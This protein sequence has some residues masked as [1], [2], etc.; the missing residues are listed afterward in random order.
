MDIDGKDRIFIKN[1]LVNHE[2]AGGFL[3]YNHPKEGLLVAVLKKE[4]ELYLIP[5][6][7]IKLDETP[8]EAALRELFEELNLHIIPKIIGKVEI[9]KYEFELPGDSRKHLKKFHKY[10]FEISSKT[11]ISPQVEENFISANWMGI[12]KASELLTYDS[13]T[14]IKAVQL[15]LKKKEVKI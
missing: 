15:Y 13:K 12:S 3:F 2:S 8:S 1:N 5:K 10:I 11:E 9:E 6:G 4:G 14:L 7:H